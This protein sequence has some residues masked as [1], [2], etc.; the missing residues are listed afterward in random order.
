MKPTT[1]A[2][3]THA[4]TTQKPVSVFIGLHNKTTPDAGNT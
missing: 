3:G 1:T 4:F 2:T